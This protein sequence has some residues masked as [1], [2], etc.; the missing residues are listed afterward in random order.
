MTEDE[1]GQAFVA[2]YYGKTIATA[3]LI[4]VTMDP[5]TIVGAADR[6]LEES[7]VEG[8]RDRVTALHETG[9]QAALRTVIQDILSEGEKE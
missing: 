1:R 8:R 4:A 7:L 5:E 9:R 6:A 2:I 3:R